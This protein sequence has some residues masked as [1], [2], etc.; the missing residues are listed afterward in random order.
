MSLRRSKEVYV[1]GSFDFRLRYDKREMKGRARGGGKGCCAMQF[2]VEGEGADTM[3]WGN[4]LGT[5]KRTSPASKVSQK[6]GGG[7]KGKGTPKGRRGPTVSQIT[8]CWTG[9]GEGRGLAAIIA[10]SS[11]IQKE[12]G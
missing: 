10:A 4:C 1:G 12:K 9:G 2:F 7:G 5:L 11:A 3:V 8:R 6:K